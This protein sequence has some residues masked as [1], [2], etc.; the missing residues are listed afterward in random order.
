MSYARHL[1][2]LR[3]LIFSLLLAFSSALGQVPN[4]YLPNVS[5]DFGSVRQGE[6]LEHR[7]EFRNVSSL[8]VKLQITGLSHPGMKVK[9]AQEVLPGAEA[10]ITVI[11]DTRFVRGETTAK[12]LL[13]LNEMES[14]SLNLLARVVP[15][16]DI[17]PYPAVFISG[18]RDE[19][20]ARRLEIVNNEEA[21]LNITAIAGAE[22]ASVFSANI[23]T[24]EAGRRYQLDVELK[25]NAPGGRSQQVIEIF[26]DHPRFSVIKVPVNV[27]VKD[28]V[29]VNPDSVDFGEITGSTTSPEIFLL[30]KHRGGIE[31]LS[32]ESDLSCIKVRHTEDETGSSHQFFVDLQG[33]DLSNGPISGHIYITTDDPVFSQFTVP[34]RAEVRKP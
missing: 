31:I 8:P 30:K 20:A 6:V 17:L 23:R 26:T 22:A 12:V 13:R 14:T 27:F 29:Y 7:F 4:V 24:V 34:V 19:K 5:F 33:S 25:P 1:V 21:A 16:I 9:A 11:W 28:E 2:V 15:P 18:F 32:I 3:I 10:S